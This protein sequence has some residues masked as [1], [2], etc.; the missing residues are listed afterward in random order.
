[1]LFQFRKLRKQ[2]AYFVYEMTQEADLTPYS[3][4]RKYLTND[5]RKAFLKAS[6][7]LPL[8]EMSFCQTLLVTGCRISEA[9]ELQVNRFDPAVR[10][11][12]LRTL[13]KRKKVQDRIMRMPPAVSDLLVAYITECNLGAT[14]R[15]W[16][17]CR[18]I[19]W[20]IVKKT[21]AD[22]KIH[23]KQATPKG[24]RHGYAHGCL[25]N[26]MNISR[27]QSRMG[28]A[29]PENTMIYLQYAGEDALKDSEKAWISLF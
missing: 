20:R 15:L 6:K 17:Y 24:L 26:G 7:R 23:G 1:M 27:L 8:P 10:T 25:D 13:K 12:E 16:P 29:R 18:T 11:I 21:M 9:L 22:A 5:E 19:G 4:T 3:N 14:D 28:H 2:N